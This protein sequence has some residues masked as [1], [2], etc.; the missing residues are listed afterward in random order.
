MTPYAKVSFRATYTRKKSLQW[1]NEVSIVAL[2]REENHSSSS[3]RDP[4]KIR[5]TLREGLICSFRLFNI[6]LLW[7]Q[8]LRL[9][10]RW[11]FWLLWFCRLCDGLCKKV[12][13][14]RETRNLRPIGT[15][16]SYRFELARRVWNE[17]IIFPENKFSEA[18][19]LYVCTDIAVK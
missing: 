15:S 6:S 11:S 18:R 10:T 3:L 19:E 13:K 7:V 1:S 12:N 17:K 16:S 9:L 4:H 2:P 8:A 14:K 5:R